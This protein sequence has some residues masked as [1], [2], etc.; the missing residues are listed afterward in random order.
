MEALAFIEDYAKNLTVASNRLSL[1]LKNCVEK[2]SDIAIQA[3]TQNREILEKFNSAAQKE[4][5]QFDKL[6]TSV[7]FMS[8]SFQEIDQLYSDVLRLS[9]ILTSL[10]QY[11]AK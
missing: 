4:I 7:D 11:A 6:M 1:E 8:Q 2:S 5:D 3:L 10:E 9:D